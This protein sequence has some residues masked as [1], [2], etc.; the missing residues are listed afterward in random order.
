MAVAVAVVSLK[1]TGCSYT[2]ASTSY[3]IRAK[4]LQTDGTAHYSG[5]LAGRRLKIGK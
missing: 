2:L 3:Q 4:Q 1:Q 5:T